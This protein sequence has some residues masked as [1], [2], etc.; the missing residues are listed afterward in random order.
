[1]SCK[2]MELLLLYPPGVTGGGVAVT[3]SGDSGWAVL[4]VAGVDGRVSGEVTGV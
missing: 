4:V 2:E 1:M 3:V